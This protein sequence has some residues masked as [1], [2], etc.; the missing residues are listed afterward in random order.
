[1]H[2]VAYAFGESKLLARYVSTFSQGAT[3]EGYFL[4]CWP[5]YDRLARL[6]ERQLQLTN[7]GP[8]LD[9]GVGF[10]FDCWYAYLY[11]GD[12]NV[13][14]E[15]YPRLIKFAE[16][17]QSIVAPDGLLPAE[18]LGVPSLY[19]DHNAFKHPKHKQCSF[20]LYTAAMF[21]HALAPLCEAMG[22]KKSAQAARFFAGKLLRA[23]VK[24]FWDSSRSLFV[25]NLP[26]VDE[27]K[28]IRYSDRTLA[29]AVLYDQCPGNRIR[30]AVEL[31]AAVPPAMGFSY[32]AN[33]GWRLWALAK[34]GRADVVVS[35]LRKRWA[36]MES[37]R[38]NN[39]L[40]E[41]WDVEP[42]STSQWSHCA[43][44]PLYVLYMSLAGIRP[45]EPG[46][47]R[48]EIVPQLADLPA[49][50]FSA[51]TPHG[52]ISFRTQGVLG[53]RTIEVETP[54]ALEGEIVLPAAEKVPLKRLRGTR[55][56]GRLAYRLPAGERVTLD[57]KET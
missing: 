22:D 12:R 6:M 45:L 41:F 30:P 8:L 13:L 17:L 25:D 39:T 14:R 34:A 27:E 31:L 11:S 5:A 24:K 46:F 51:H 48:Y 4:D 54:L 57:L 7:W 53:S 15:P 18:N 47:R 1:M 35:D 20:N 52:P 26:W 36:T 50:R 43:V 44:I 37:V 3:L 16:Y 29:T 49:L 32:P 40:Q 38:L 33:A 23:T 21:D 10:N 55:P 9:H 42:D 2:A 56:L 28:E 19:I